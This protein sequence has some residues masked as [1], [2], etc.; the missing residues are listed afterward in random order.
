MGV[1]ALH[2]ESLPR[3]QTLQPMG[4]GTPIAATHPKLQL[5]AK[6]WDDQLAAQEAGRIRT[7]EVRASDYIEAAQKY[8]SGFCTDMKNV[9]TGS[10]EKHCVDG[11]V[12]WTPG[13]VTAAE[14]KGGIVSIV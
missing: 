12:T 10:K 4:F 14:Q 8:V 7:T 3:L 5:R 9:K 2:R 11:I 6:M 1:N 13:D